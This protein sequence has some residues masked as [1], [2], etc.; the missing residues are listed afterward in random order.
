[1]SGIESYVIGRALERN[2]GTVTR[3]RACLGLELS[4]LERKL[5]EYGLSD[6]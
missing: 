2:R 6:A 4:V 5:T 3:R 1:M